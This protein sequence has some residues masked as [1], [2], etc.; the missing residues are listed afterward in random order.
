M[1]PWPWDGEEV[2]VDEVALTFSI[3][4]FAWLLIVQQPKAL[5]IAQAALSRAHMEITYL[6][7][8]CHGFSSLY[9]FKLGLSSNLPRMLQ[10]SLCC[11]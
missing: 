11:L 3:R 4:K 8:F 2:Q 6:V 10:L 7:S 1:Q 5:H 9:N